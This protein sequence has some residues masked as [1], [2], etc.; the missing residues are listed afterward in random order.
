MTCIAQSGTVMNG[1]FVHKNTNTLTR[2]KDDP[3]QKN[4]VHP[5]KY[6]HGFVVLCFVFGYIITL[7][8][9]QNGRHFADDIFALNFFY[10]NLRISNK[11]SLEFLLKCPIYNIPALVKIMTWGPSQ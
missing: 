6:V 7:R 4:K 1:R 5:M 3:P 10:Q 8:P 11:I 9:R 2:K